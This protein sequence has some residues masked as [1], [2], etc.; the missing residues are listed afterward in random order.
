MNQKKSV[1]VLLVDDS[2]DDRELILMNLRRG[3]YNPEYHGV[4][5]EKA[6]NEALDNHEWDL[7]LCDYSMPAFDGITALNILNKKNK[8][9]PFIL[10]SGA[11]GEELAVK[12]MKAGAHDYL[13]KDNLQR[14]VPAIEREINEAENRKKHREAQRERDWLLTVIQHSLNEIYI[15]DS[16]NLRFRYLNQAAINNLGYG[17]N[18]I[19]SLTPYDINPQID[20]RREFN[21]IIQPLLN[22]ELEKELFIAK[23]LRKDGSS[24]PI[25]IHLQLIEQGDER[26]FTAIG[27]DLTDREKDAQRI[28]EQKEIARELALHSKYKSE[29]LA[30]MSHELRTPL[31]SIILLSK[32]LLKAKD[33][34]LSDDQA[35]FVDV[36][37][38]SGNNLLELINEVLDLS[39]IEAGEME[40]S[41]KKLN[42]AEMIRSIQ[43]IFNPIADEK[44]VQFEVTSDQNVPQQLVTDRMR[45]E[46]VLKNLLSNAFKFTDKGSVRLH[47]FLPDETMGNSTDLMLGS[48]VIDTG[49]GIP[50]DKQSLIFES[51]RQ[52][53]GSTQR[54]YGGTGLGL[55][56]CRQIAELLGGK[57]TVS[58][59]EG[60][61]S[62]FTFII[63][64]DST[65]KIK[66]TRQVNSAA[67]GVKK[68]EQSAPAQK[69]ARLKPG[70]IE[71]SQKGASGHSTAATKQNV[72]I[73]TSDKK[74][75]HTLSEAFERENQGV[76]FESH[77]K[78]VIEKMIQFNPSL[79]ILDPYI[80]DLSGWSLAKQISQTPKVSSI[81]VWFIAP[82]NQKIPEYGSQ[83]A[84]GVIKLPINKKQFDQLSDN[85]AKN[86]NHQK[87]T[88]LL[89]DDNEMHNTALREFVTEVTDQ[90][91]TAESAKSAFELLDKHSVDCIILDLTLPD[92]T[93]ADILKKLSTDQQFSD[94]PVIVYSGKSLTNA[95]KS[96]LLDH[97]SDVILK[98]VGSH[99]RLMNKVSELIGSSQ[100]SEKY[101]SF[102][103]GARL[104]GKKVLIVEDDQSSF[105]SLS[106]LLKASGIEVLHATNGR[107][108][109]KCLHESPDIDVVLMD[110]MMPD[111]DGLDALTEIRREKKWQ[112]L[113]IISITAKAMR[114]DRETCLEMGATDYVSKPIDPQKLLELLSIWTS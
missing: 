94:I 67:T 59:I 84:Q 101:P 105:F 87:K 2:A 64:A 92:A 114:G 52:V 6:F 76:I 69:P 70:D 65:G 4:D 100:L 58:S 99:S 86:I 68:A 7:I 108:A 18:E 79:V 63:P 81:P 22:G 56:I 30:N 35:K 102:Y 95:E 50:E 32:L 37:H 93:G 31:N 83:F 91:L 49:I 45:V 26:F 25:E 53:D 90:C 51:F 23:H 107:D 21:R 36:I 33:K 112:Q 55:S 3:G 110:I 106:S 14:L 113:P 57:I 61:G 41:L 109:I 5:T 29:F 97:A 17:D 13:M 42:T 60:E 34:N 40:I 80:L 54:T 11:I 104:S 20:N 77:G 43:N 82:E 72:L 73:A 85:C 71:P 9:I 78:Q 39:K 46:Q 44:D 75:Q 15:F 96:E 12:A 24:Y 19:T 88:L 38:Q 28:R 48:K 27:F 98:N 89:I 16:K 47:L 62:T 8:D 74:L 103:N 66:N 10:V 1:R 111:M